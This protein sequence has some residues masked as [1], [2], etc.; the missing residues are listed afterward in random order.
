[1]HLVEEL[2]ANSTHVGAS[3]GQ[4]KLVN[5]IAREQLGKLGLCLMLKD[6]SSG[7]NTDTEL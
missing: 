6:K 5:R 7:E 1:L 2:V 3:Q 4:H